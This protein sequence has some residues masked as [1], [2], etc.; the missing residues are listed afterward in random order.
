M[1]LISEE[2]IQFPKLGTGKNILIQ[3]CQEI[4]TGH[5]KAIPTLAKQSVPW[6]QLHRAVTI[7][8]FSQD[9]KPHVGALKTKLPKKKK[10]PFLH[11]HI[12]HFITE[13]CDKV[14]IK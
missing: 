2:K 9:I 4:L 11:T 1:E 5:R 6:Q 8:V 12:L 3:D 10:N 7:E 13:T 14:E